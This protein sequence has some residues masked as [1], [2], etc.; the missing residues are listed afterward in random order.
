MCFSGKVLF[1]PLWLLLRSCL[2]F[3]GRAPWSYLFV[4]GRNPL[5][6]PDSGSRIFSAS[7]PEVK[8]AMIDL[9]TR[10]GVSE[11]FQFNTDGV[12]RSILWD[13]T[14]INQ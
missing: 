10:H 11:R 12:L 9:L 14:I 5:P 8:D 6:S 4:K 13:A 1:V 7:S 3:D 2:I